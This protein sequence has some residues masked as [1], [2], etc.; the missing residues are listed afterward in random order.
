[1]DTQG[2]AADRAWTFMVYL[3][4]DNNLEDYASKDL[5]EMK[6]VGSTPNVAVVAQ[7]D[8]MSDQVTRRFYLRQGAALTA[9][10]VANLPETDTG[11]PACLIDFVN[12]AIEQYPARRYALVLWN[13]GSG[14]KE[15]DI[16]QAAQRVGTEPC[17][18]RQVMRGI[19]DRK[20]HALFRTS[21]EWYVEN[22][23][24]A[25]AY[26]DSSEDFLDNA[27][28]KRVLEQVRAKIGRPL[29]FLGFDA[30][31]MNMLEVHYQLREQ[32]CAIAGSQELEPGDGW[33][34]NDILRALTQQPD[35]T[36][37]QLGVAIVGAYTDYYQQNFPEVGVTQSAVAVGRLDPVVAAVDQLAKALLAVRS[38]QKL[39]GLIYAACRSAQKFNDPDYFDLADLCRSL[40]IA[41][42][43]GAVGQ[44][45]QGV[46]D[47]L[48]GAG[49]PVLAVRDH[50][51]SVSNAT[52]LSIY[53]PSRKVSPLYQNLDFAK[54]SDW[55]RFLSHFL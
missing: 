21:L 35:M 55:S 44:S 54:A 1:M 49:T 9:D 25:I 4:G 15:D 29:D 32:V 13:H 8:R 3:A 14:W 46:V 45:A 41:D 22:P 26:D 11:D 12:W 43:R 38:P 19:A 10:L 5:R 36:P 47:A 2:L 48:L 24:R 7:L 23:E 27:E 17:I 40:V 28:L 50:G 51:K 33:P 30:C 16:Y 52:G 18:T 31:L 6:M 42:P 37:E 39:G 34:Y 20:K 53:L